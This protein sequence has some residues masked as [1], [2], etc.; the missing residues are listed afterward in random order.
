MITGNIGHS[1][2]FVLG[3]GAVWALVACAQD[4]WMVPVQSAATKDPCDEANDYGRRAAAADN[5]QVKLG[6]QRIA[7]TKSRECAA[8]S[9]G[10]TAGPNAP[11]NPGSTGAS[12]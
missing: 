1:M 12:H 7:D 11:S 5:A 2:R 6:L 3:A 8:K 9:T 4:P 10:V